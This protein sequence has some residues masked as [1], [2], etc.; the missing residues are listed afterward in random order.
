MTIKDGNRTITIGQPDEQ[1]RSKV[2]V[3]DGE[4]EPSEYVVDFTDDPGEQPE[5]GVIRAENGKAVIQDGDAAISLEQV[6]GP[7][8]RL[9]MTVDDGTPETYDVDF[10][11][12]S[13]VPGSELPGVP[14]FPETPHTLP[15]VPT[16]S[17]SGGDFGGGGGGGGGSFG[18]GGT[19]GS[20]IGG[21]PQPGTMVGAGSPDTTGADRA[22]AAA[23]GGAGAGG[24][25]SAGSGQQGAVGG[26]PMGGMGAGGQGG[27]TTR[28]SKWRTTGQLFED[29][30]PAANFSG[31]VGRDPSE[32][33][34][35]R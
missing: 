18:G 1:G 22:A 27:D 11:P 26:M 5:E 4:G 25:G 23:S 7:N 12:D 8:D 13:V 19:P 14:D 20:S 3:D 24:G 32:K 29:G 34:P 2:T 9:K 17:S 15:D 16:P 21:G 6:P 30:D 10:G 31:V 33:T 28:Q 35:K